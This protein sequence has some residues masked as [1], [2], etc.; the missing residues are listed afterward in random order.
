MHETGK[1]IT[2]TAQM[3]HWILWPIS[4]SLFVSKIFWSIVLAQIGGKMFDAAAIKLC[5]MHSNVY[6]ALDTAGRLS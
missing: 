4:N 5:T 1:R 3:L 2:G 6:Y